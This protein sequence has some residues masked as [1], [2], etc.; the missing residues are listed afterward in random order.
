MITRIQIDGFKS[1]RNFQTEF[2]PLTVIAGANASGKSNLF[3]ALHL[4][5]RL[6]EVDLKTA[7]SSLRGEPIEQFTYYGDG[8]YTNTMSFVVDLLVNQ[9]VKDN[10]GG[11]AKIK[12]TRLRYSLSIERV[13]NEHGINEMFVARETLEPIKKQDDQWAKVNIPNEAAKDWILSNSKY[14]LRVEVSSLKDEPLSVVLQ[15]GKYKGYTVGNTVVTKVRLQQTYISGFNKIET[16]HLLAVQQEMKQWQFPILSPEALSQPSPYYAEDTDLSSGENLAAVLH[17]IKAE[18]TFAFRAIARK[19]N[20]LVPSL[21]DLDVIDDKTNQ[22][23]IIQV[24]GQNER[25]FSSR[26]M[27]AGTLRLLALCVLNYDEAYKGVLAFEEPENGI[28]PFRIKDVLH[29]LTEL[30]TDFTDIAFP[31][32]QVIINT[33]S[34]VLVRDTFALDRSQSTTVWLAQLVTQVTN[35]MNKRITLSITKILPVEASQTTINYSEAEAK[36]TVAQVIKYLE[37][38]TAEGVIET[39]TH[40][41]E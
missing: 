6:A 31:L 11:V 12:F 36:L 32:R 25:R 13:T 40:P 33:H 15:D 5:S 17:R 22:Q 4:L 39:L 29:L 9:Q 10:W 34:P 23:Y 2:S 8:Q 28:H 27:S 14:N 35:I 21:T 41:N 7:F 30:S 1:F 3:D 18:D 37:S 16:P 24:K 20:S 19:L 38:A 26:V